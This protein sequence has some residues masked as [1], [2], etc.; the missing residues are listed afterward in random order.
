MPAASRR[1]KTT[2]R[3][4]VK[5]DQ[6]ALAHFSAEGATLNDL[7]PL[8]RLVDPA[9]FRT[10]W[11]PQSLHGMFCK[12]RSM[13]DHNDYVGGIHRVR[14]CYFSDGLR[15]DNKKKK[16]KKWVKQA[17]AAGLQLSRLDL[18]IWNEFI[19]CDSAIVFWRTPADGRV[20]VPVVLDCEMCEYSDALGFETLKVKPAKVKTLSAGQKAALGPRW[21][22]ALQAGKTIELDPSLGEN[23][24]V[25][26]WGKLGKGLIWPRL[27]QILDK[28]GTRELLEIADFGA[29]WESGDIYRHISK[30]Y[31]IKQGLH[32]GEA[33]NHITAPQSKA[34]QRDNKA[35]RGPRTAVTNFD[36]SIAWKFL[37]PKFF[38]A[39]KYEAVMAKLKTWG[40]PAALLYEAGQT[41]PQLMSAFAVEGRRARSMVGPFLSSILNDPTFHGDLEPPEE[42]KVIWNPQSFLD[43]KMMLEWVRAGSASGLI[44]PQTCRHALGVD[45]DD[46]CALMKEALAD[47]TGYRPVFE[48]KQGLLAAPAPGRPS[49]KPG[50]SSQ[51]TGQE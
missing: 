14:L 6:L 45:N 42:L 44:S 13:L 47:P 1:R 5:A 49:D 41:S 20:A 17:T 18:D 30:G 31:E 37:D 15:F 35:K 24:K 48:A 19:L 38:D 8:G 23:F 2:A 50:A 28:L 21:V 27:G 29:A 4:D 46:E 9:Q 3:S 7:L 32:A 25:L 11:N 40:G 10:E 51:P 33:R 16:V 43:T 34:I 36:V 26:T 22:E 39:K 12:C